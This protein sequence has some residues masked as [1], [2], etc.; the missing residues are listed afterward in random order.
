MPTKVP[1]IREDGLQIEEARDFQER[2]WTIERVAWAGFGLVLIA[3]IA[4]FTGSGGIF[5]RQTA[6]AGGVVLDYPLV[7]RRQAA[8][9]FELSLSNTQAPTL[10][11]SREFSKA[12]QLET[13][14]PR[15]DSE[16]A[17]PE[18]L[19]L[20]FEGRS[21]GTVFLHARPQSPGLASFEISTGG[22]TRTVR[23]L[24]MP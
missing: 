22:E 20:T 15:P 6:A 21:G 19:E 24:V 7:A 16:R 3:A 9:T 13:V 8:E 18:G 11:L 2:F 23:L 5:A 14:Q 1:P 10:V 12:F 4:G 17:V